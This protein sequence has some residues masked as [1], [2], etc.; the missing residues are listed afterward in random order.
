MRAPRAWPRRPQALFGASSPLRTAGLPSPDRPGRL[1]RAGAQCNLSNEER[2]ARGTS[3]PSPGAAA[4]YRVPSRTNQLGDGR[5]LSATSHSLMRSRGKRPEGDTSMG[6][7]VIGAGALVMALAIPAFASADKPTQTD[8][9]NAAQEC[10]NLR[11]ST[12][13]T[14]MAF[15]IK[16]GTNAND[17]NAF[18]KCVSALAKEEADE[19][20]DALKNAAKECK[21]EQ[22]LSDEDFEDLLPEHAGETFESFYG[23]NKNMRNAFGKC[24]S[25][26]VHDDED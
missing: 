17:R 14:E 20:E 7:R 18:G 1:A 4:C 11:G 19:R 15:R 3:S 9:H 2:G 25:G 22:A 6:R 24:V 16:Y 10:R 21:A 23:T 26:K 8:R 13:A 12:P 5:P